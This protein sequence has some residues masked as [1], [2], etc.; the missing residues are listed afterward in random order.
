MKA[1]NQTF[2]RVLPTPGTKIARVVGII[3]IGTVETEWEGNKKNT[4]KIRVTWELPDELASFKEGDPEKP[5]TVS[6][7]F[8]F[9]M[10]N[11]SALRPIV[12]G[13]IGTSLSDEEAANFDIEAILG[14]ASLLS[15]S[16]DEGQKGKYVSVKTTASLLKGMECPP[17]VNPKK[18]ISY[19]DWNQEEF[20]KLPDFIKEKMMVSQEYQKLKGSDK[21]ES[22]VDPDEIPF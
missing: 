3:Y 19:L 12:E 16:I 11:K 13:I 4:F 20:D 7:E 18:V 8:T 5:F 10:G 6:R 2:N 1:P 14:M 22:V 17:Q 9:S 21:K 15:I